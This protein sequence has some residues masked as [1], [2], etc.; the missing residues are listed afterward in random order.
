VPLLADDDPDCVVEGA[1]EDVPLLADDDPDCVVDV[2]GEDVPLVVGATVLVTGAVAW[3]AV[4]VAAAAESVAGVGADCVLDAGAE[5]ALWT[6]AVAA[7]VAV[8]TGSVTPETERSAEAFG[9]TKPPRIA[10]IPAARASARRRTRQGPGG[11][12]SGPTPFGRSEW[13]RSDNPFP[14]VV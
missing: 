9:T 10:M 13:L 11:P 3:V 14:P 8:A 2:A 5:V 4:D 7:D 12:A 6:G 1:G